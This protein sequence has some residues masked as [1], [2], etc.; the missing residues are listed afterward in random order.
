MIV[1]KTTTYTLLFRDDSSSLGK[2]DLQS[3]KPTHNLSVPWITGVNKPLVT[4]SVASAARNSG[5]A[6]DLSR[7]TRDMSA[8]EKKRRPIHR[9]PDQARPPACARH[10][11]N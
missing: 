3:K 7:K 5:K 8:R 2:E 10:V 1:Y 9:C 4:P 6:Q 11:D